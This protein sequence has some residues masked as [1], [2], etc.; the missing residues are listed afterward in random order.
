MKLIIA[1]WKSNKSFS[2]AQ[3]WL[4]DAQPAMGGLADVTA[5]LAPPMAFVA[6]L[7]QPVQEMGWQLAVQDFSPFPA[8]SYTGAVSGINLHDLGVKYALV[9]HSERRHYFHES[10]QDVARKIEQALDVGIT[11]IVCTDQPTLASQAAAIDD[12]LAKQ[13][14]VAFEPAGTIGSGNNAPIDEVK[15]FR[16]QAERLF[17][18]VPFLYGGSADEQNIGEYLLVTDGAIIGTAALDVKQFMQVLT[19]ARGTPPAAT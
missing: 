6:A 12:E 15:A 14:I 11:P 8:G 19:A 18:A 16:Q 2:Q 1:N 17:G 9:G 5:I 13:C 10:V 3:S 4:K 7:S